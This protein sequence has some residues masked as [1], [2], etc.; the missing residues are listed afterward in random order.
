[1]R[2]WNGCCLLK[3]QIEFSVTKI[4]VCCHLDC[5]SMRIKGGLKTFCRLYLNPCV[6]PANSIFWEGVNLCNV[7]LFTHLKL[8]SWLWVL[9]N[10]QQPVNLE[11]S[12]WYTFPWVGCPDYSCRRLRRW[13]I[14][15][16]PQPGK[17]TSSEE[18]S[19]PLSRRGWELNFAKI[20]LN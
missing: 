9:E 18:A 3:T 10:L 12:S 17:K 15:L 11:D 16:N 1:M 5:Q 4:R 14:K 8:V 19:A 6:K 20:E 13:E 7:P 2:V